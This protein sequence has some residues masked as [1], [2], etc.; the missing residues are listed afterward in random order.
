MSSTSAPSHQITTPEQ[1]AD[2]MAKRADT[3][4]LRLGSRLVEAGVATQDAVNAA[5]AAQQAGSRGRLGN[6]LVAMGAAHPDE[7][8]RIMEQYHGTPFVDL[9]RYPLNPGALKKLSA[10][11]VIQARC[12][13][14]EL[15]DNTLFV[16]FPEG[17]SWDVINV[18]KFASGCKNVVPM[19]SANPD[20]LKR[21][22]AR[23]FSQPE[24]TQ[25][26]S[27]SI[28]E[29]Q[30]AAATKGDGT[31]GGQFRQL[32][33]LALSNSASDIHVHPQPDGS[34]RV[35]LRIDGFLRNF[36]PL[37]EKVAIALVR[38]LEVISGMGLRGQ[39]EAKEGRLSISQDGFPVDLRVSIIPGASGDSVVLRVLDPALF[40][41]S[42]SHLGLVPSQHQTLTGMMT[43]PQGLFLVTGPTGSGKTTTLYT[44]LKQMHSEKHLHVATAEDPVEYRLPG[45]NQ[46]DT[47]NF[48]QTLK[49]LLR[50]DPDVLMVGELRDDEA[51]VTAVNAALTGH[52][53]LSTVHANDSVGAVHRLLSL[54]VPHVLLGSCL[55]GVMSQ[56]L[57]RL[58][59]KVCEG[60]GCENCHQTGYAGRRLVAELARTKESFAEML[61]ANVTYADILAHT[62]FV[63]GLRLDDVLVEMA[64]TGDTDWVEIAS[65]V[66]DPRRL[67]AN[68][69]G[70]MGLAG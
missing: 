1:L 62:D 45:I 26:R 31:A 42:I 7:V 37:T 66:A 68:I 27:A 4:N 63:G 19:R 28:S 49:Q 38:H 60:T 18:L 29:E 41:A 40:P 25:I 44:M 47:T 13:P 17:A 6:I 67:P 15:I 20:V 10:A 61:R 69:R 14:F 54:G 65:L 22:V 53:V 70:A 23:H 39:R 58:R 34:R 50:H 48:A 5:L 36:P 56:R 55:T 43:R 64:K 35:M 59:C 30:Y 12:I 52:L 16:A 9:A 57:V 33:A 2:M 51:A 21:L 11:T 32:L 3:R 8:E 46:F 24:K